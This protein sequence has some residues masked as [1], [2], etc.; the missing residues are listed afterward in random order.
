MTTCTLFFREPSYLNIFRNAYSTASSCQKAALYTSVSAGWT[1]LAASCGRLLILKNLPDKEHAVASLLSAALAV[2]ECTGATGYRTCRSNADIPSSTLT[3]ALI[4][5]QV[6]L[7]PAISLI[8]GMLIVEPQSKPIELIVE[9]LC[10]ITGCTSLL[11]T[12]TVCHKCLTVFK[13]YLHPPL[14]EDV[15]MS[16]SQQ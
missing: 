15:E 5:Y 8:A 2:V 13:N 1:F 12:M 7:K 16:L 10:L 9:E 3:C 4:P 14:S 6:V 11:L